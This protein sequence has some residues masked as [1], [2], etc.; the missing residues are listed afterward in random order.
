MI[1]RRE[2]SSERQDREAA[3]RQRVDEAR[4]KLAG[5][6]A[7][8]VEDPLARRLAATLPVSEGAIQLYLPLLLPVWLELSDLV[9]VRFG[10]A[11]PRREVRSKARRRRAKQK[12]K[13]HKSPTPRLGNVVK[14]PRQA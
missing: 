5:V 7:H 10:L 4:T 8:T 14:F 2:A 13:P 12:A 9:L 6:G 3:A 1:T 11:P